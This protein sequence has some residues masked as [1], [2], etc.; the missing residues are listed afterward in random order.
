MSGTS[1]EAED[2]L[3]EDTIEDAPICIQVTSLGDP[4][5][6][7]AFFGILTRGVKGSFPRESVKLEI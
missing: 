4:D 1:D 7:D 2:S 3:D 6:F 5:H